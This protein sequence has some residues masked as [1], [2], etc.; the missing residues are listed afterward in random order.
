LSALL[1]TLPVFKSKLEAG[2]GFWAIGF[3]GAIY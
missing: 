1:N 2:T 3:M